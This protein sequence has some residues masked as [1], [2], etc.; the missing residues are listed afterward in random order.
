MLQDLPIE[1]N[2]VLVST[3]DF[4]EKINF[5]VILKLA[6]ECGPIKTHNYKEKQSF[7]FIQFETSEVREY[8][9]VLLLFFWLQL[10]LF[11]LFICSVFFFFFYV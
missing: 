2:V 9:S 8:V 4:G 10:F 7:G 5:S 11:S 3:S 6:E 1:P